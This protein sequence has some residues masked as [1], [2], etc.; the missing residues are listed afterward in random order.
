MKIRM[1]LD[2]AP[3]STTASP[4]LDSF[5]AGDFLVANS[6][7]TNR[8]GEK[9]GLRLFFQRRFFRWRSRVLKLKPRLWQN[10]LR[11]IPLLTNSATNC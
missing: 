1:Y 8:P 4:Q 6:T 5:G 11:P 7:G 2:P 9:V 10:S 3:A